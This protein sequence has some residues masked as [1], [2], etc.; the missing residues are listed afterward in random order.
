VAKVTEKMGNG[1]AFLG[2][3]CYSTYLWHTPLIL[4]FSV[5]ERKVLRTELPFAVLMAIYIVGSF[6]LGIFF[7]RLFE[8]PVLRLRDRFIPMYQQ[9]ALNLARSGASWQTNTEAAS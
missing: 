9:P 6:A 7:A 5:F 2:K 8:L 3:H 4:A 1:C